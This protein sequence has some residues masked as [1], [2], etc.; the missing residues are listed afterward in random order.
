MEFAYS[1]SNMALE[2]RGITMGY[3]KEFK[4]LAVDIDGTLLNS[5]G[6]LTTK[7]LQLITELNNQDYIFVLSTGRPLIGAKAISKQI[8][9]DIPIIGGN[10]AIVATSQ[11][12]KIIVQKDLDKDVAREIIKIATQYQASLVIWCQDELFI[13]RKDKYTEKYGSLASS[14][15]QLPDDLSVIYSKD[16]TKIIWFDEPERL[17]AIQKEIKPR[18]KNKANFF[19]SNPT[20]LEFVNK[21]ASK[22]K[23]LQVIK[24]YYSL[25]RSEIVAV[26]D[27]FNDVAMI[28]YAGLGIA[29]ANADEEIKQQ[30]DF[31]TLTN[32]E[33]GVDFVIENFF[34]NH[35]H[36]NGDHMKQYQIV[37]RNLLINKKYQVYPLSV[38]VV[39]TG[40][41]AMIH[42]DQ[43]YLLC[44]G[45]LSQEFVGEKVVIHRIQ[46]KKCPLTHE[47]A[48]QL[49]QVLRFTAPIPVLREDRSFGV[50][51]RLGIA[52]LGHIE[53]FK[54]YDAF[55]VLV[56]QS[57]RE[58][59]LTN[60]RYEDV[61]DCVSFAT[62]KAGYKK[63]FGADGDHLKHPE[64]IEYALRLGFSM[65]TLDCSEYID[66]LVNSMSEEE[67][68]KI[69]LPATISKKYLNKKFIIEDVDL[70]FSAHELKKCYLIYHKAIEFAI[71]IYND[72]IKDKL[73]QVDFEISIDET[74]TPTTPLEHFY[75]ANELADHEVTVATIAP[76][77]CGEFQKG[78]DYVGDIKQFEKEF[79]VHAMIARHFGY[80]LSIH[81]GS[82]KFST[83]PIIGQYTKGRFHVKTAGTNWLE[84]MAVIAIKAPKLYRE[85]HQYALEVFSEACQYYHVTTDLNQIPN[86]D[87]LQD[88]ELIGLFSNNDARQL[89]HITYGLILNHRDAQDNYVFKDQLY[90]LW[91]E[92]ADLYKERLKEHIGRHLEYLYS[93]FK[94]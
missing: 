22:A 4:L 91:E 76:R 66:N 39:E 31:V 18:L 12:H 3:S 56:Q 59:N 42:Q 16:I 78:I 52:S 20:Y 60:R 19:T 25:K 77:F 55:P 54:K 33:G 29:M 26:G 58:L 68:E 73:D 65:I 38:N 41:I 24:T 35:N 50:G 21:E 89:I 94:K 47:N 82:D 6:V 69:T 80:K 11:S 44:L 46:G 9:F 17:K 49:R 87:T 7:T 64:E 14:Y 70:I 92:Q 53:V 90:Q 67:L 75:V 62:L 79:E 72:Y 23:A 63:G 36:S 51:D 57:I 13:N 61:L 37:G 45:D 34:L 10:G 32:D 81:S 30:A 84:A 93:G 85:I 74:S 88:S 83:F 8:P 86:L 43:D 15:P 5:S 40:I 1:D 71:Q 28:Q 2:I 48:H 27:G